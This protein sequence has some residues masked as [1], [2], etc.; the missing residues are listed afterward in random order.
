MSTKRQN[1]FASCPITF[2]K[3]IG[4]TAISPAACGNVGKV[5]DAYLKINKYI[6]AMIMKFL[7]GFSKLC[8]IHKIHLNVVNI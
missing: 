3:V 6:C 2:H 8:S 1:I 7:P 5:M 4:T